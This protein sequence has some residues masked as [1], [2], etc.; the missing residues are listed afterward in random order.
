MFV[1]VYIYIYIYLVTRCEKSAV[2]DYLLVA[3]NSNFGCAVMA[4][5]MVMRR[6]C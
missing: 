1:F 6:L 4:E 2:K 3:V 5:L